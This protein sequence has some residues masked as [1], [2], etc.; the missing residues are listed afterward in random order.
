MKNMSLLKLAEAEELK[1][2]S[3]FNG[4]SIYRLKRQIENN[5]IESDNQIKGRMAN[6]NTIIEFEIIY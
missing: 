4:F 3:L 5:M 1:E 2:F 6:I